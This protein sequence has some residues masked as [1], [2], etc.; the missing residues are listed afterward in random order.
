MPKSLPE[1][2]SG[3]EAL[4]PYSMAAEANGFVFLAGQVALDP[5]S[6]QKVD[7]D[8][9]AQAERVLDNIGALLGDLGL[10]FT[11]VVKASVFLADIGDFAA[12][13]EVYA[14]YFDTEPPARSTFQAGAL[15]GGYLVEIEVIA[16]R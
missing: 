14:R 1:T 13:N 10:G 6:G 4:G 3:P 12:V 8:V 11:D 9:T 15:P 7:G 5:A 16:A 2:P